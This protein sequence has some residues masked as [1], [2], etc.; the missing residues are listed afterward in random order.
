ML[1]TMVGMAK[2]KTN[3]QKKKQNTH[4]HKT[5]NKT[6]QKLEGWS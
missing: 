6:S 2:T 1:G 5:N 3:K 4:T